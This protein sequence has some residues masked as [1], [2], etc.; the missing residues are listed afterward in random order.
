MYCNYCRKEIK[1]D[2]KYLENWGDHSSKQLALMCSDVTYYHPRCKKRENRMAVLGG[3][4]VLVVLAL[5][6]YLAETTRF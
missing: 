4:V 6:I 3:I 1:E 2:E 5:I